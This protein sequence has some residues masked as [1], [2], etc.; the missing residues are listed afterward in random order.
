MKK[1]TMKLEAILAQN[2][3]QLMES[4]PGLDTI[5]KVSIRSGVSR[6]TVDR[7]RK[8]EVSTKIETV[9]M[10]AA[11][12]GVSPLE[13]LKQSGTDAASNDPA[14]ARAEYTL[15]WADAKEDALLTAYRSTDDEGRRTLDNIASIVPKVSFAAPLNKAE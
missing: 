1:T 8:A 11:A 13:L 3:S 10:L 7:V 2:I 15:H 12:F 6:G 14:P 5:E 9:E 4:T